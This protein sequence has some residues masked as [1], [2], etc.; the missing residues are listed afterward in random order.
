MSSGAWFALGRAPMCLNLT[1]EWLRLR[2]SAQAKRQGEK[3]KKK[4]K[5]TDRRASLF[6]EFELWRCTVLV[7]GSKD[8]W[9]FTV[10][11]VRYKSG[12]IRWYGLLVFYMF[13]KKTMQ[14]PG[15]EIPNEL[16]Q[17]EGKAAGFPHRLLLIIKHREFFYG[18]QT[19]H[20]KHRD[21]KHL[22]MRARR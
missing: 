21:Q 20:T 7:W 13:P 8:F 18:I 15:R 9:D 5:R 6:A 2:P 16:K 1:A 3:K 12:N 11:C 10:L 19:K 14:T 22:D 17:E 4:F